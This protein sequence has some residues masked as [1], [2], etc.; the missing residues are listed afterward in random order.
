MSLLKAADKKKKKQLLVM[1]ICLV[2]FRGE[3]L[4]LARNP[5]PPLGLGK[6]SELVSEQIFCF[7]RIKNEKGS[8][9]LKSD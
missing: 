4:Q 5:Y 7:Q 2:A 6:H 8:L 3:R 1:K 9:A